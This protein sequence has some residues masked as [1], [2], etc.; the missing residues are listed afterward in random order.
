VVV[1]WV[2]AA[3]GAVVVAAGVAKYLYPS[4]S[5][6]KPPFPSL[7]DFLYLCAYLLFIVALGLLVRRRGEG[8]DRVELLDVAIIAVGA[9]VLSLVFLIAPN[10]H[11]PSRSPSCCWTWCCS[12]WRPAWR[13]AP[14]RGRRR[15]GCCWDG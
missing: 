8:G 15:C 2:L 6:V 5:G 4:L 9:G 10:L 13:S 7:G 12:Q 11:D 1:W 14:P 3:G